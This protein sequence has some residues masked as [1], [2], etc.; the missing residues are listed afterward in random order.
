MKYMVTEGS[1]LSKDVD[2][3]PVFIQDLYSISKLRFLS[4]PT[5]VL[6]NNFSNSG[7]MAGKNF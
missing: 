7:S 5:A 4:W 6:E 2:S 3:F 1:F